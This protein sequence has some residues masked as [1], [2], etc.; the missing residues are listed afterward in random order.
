MG[1]F[2]TPTGPRRARGR[3]KPLLDLMRMRRAEFRIVHHR[4]QL[5]FAQLVVPAQQHQH[6][7]TVGH[8]HQAL[9]LRRLRQ[10]G[11]RGHFRNGLAPGGGELFR[12]PVPLG[13]R[14]RRRG[15][16]GH[17]LFQVGGIAAAGADR[18]EILTRVRRHHELMRLAAAHGA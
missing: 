13:I 6:W 16:R 14:R 11:E 10:P 4:A 15:W 1:M 2:F 18:H 9:H 3:A 12:R 7:L 8:Q 5:G 17:G